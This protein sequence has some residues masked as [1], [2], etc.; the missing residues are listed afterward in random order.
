ME[1]AE[2]FQG[3][4]LGSYNL[5]GYLGFTGSAH[6]F[7]LLE[8]L[9]GMTCDAFLLSNGKDGNYNF[10]ETFILKA[11]ALINLKHQSIV[12]VYDCGV[13]HKFP[14]LIME[15]VDGPTLLDMINGAKH[16]MVRIPINATVFII[17][18]V[19]AGLAHAHK[20][21]IIHG[22]LNSKNI[23]LEETGLVRV[24]DFGFSYL[25]TQDK[26][27]SKGEYNLPYFNNLS[28]HKQK[29]KD[30]FNL[31]VIFYELLTGEKPHPSIPTLFQ[32]KNPL[33]THI[34]PP[35]SLVPEIPA[36]VEDVVLRAISPDPKDRYQTIE[37]FVN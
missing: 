31:G 10:S 3:K 25:V 11:S 28:L 32:G 9:E 19:A 21:E 37:R 12:S 23:L 22:N 6:A 33:T 17:S 27:F 4:T 26:E 36:R 24:S 7:K 29:L 15:H 16:K 34:K 5:G 2:R 8:S 13:D 14:Y 1:I 30:I 35:T 18:S 20:L